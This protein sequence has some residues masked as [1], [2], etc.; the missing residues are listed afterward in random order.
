MLELS[1]FIVLPR[2]RVVRWVENQRMKQLF[3]LDL[4]EVFANLHLPFIQNL[5]LGKALNQAV[6][7]VVAVLRLSDHISTQLS[8]FVCVSC[9]TS[10]KRGLVAS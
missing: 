2:T 3:G 9:E 1:A 7:A 6:D 10:W 5:N 4:S 8:H